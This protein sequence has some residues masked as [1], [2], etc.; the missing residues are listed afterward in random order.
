MGAWGSVPAV[1]GA[2]VLEAPPDSAHRVVRA[3]LAG[4]RPWRGRGSAPADP[5]L[6]RHRPSTRRYAVSLS[7]MARHVALVSKAACQ[8]RIGE[9][10][11]PADQRAD[12]VEAA[13]HEVSVRARPQ[14]CPKVPGE[15]QAAQARDRFQ[16]LGPHRLVQAGIEE[17]AGRVDSA[18]VPGQELPSLDRGIGRS[19]RLGEVEHDLIEAVFRDR[20]APA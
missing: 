10:R 1:G 9:R 7:E 17:R 18:P 14:K 19:K 13:H 20:R 2:R 3:A 16:L 15:R 8:C 11:P 6:D 4:P 12:P 5:L